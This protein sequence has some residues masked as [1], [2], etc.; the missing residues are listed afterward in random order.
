MTIARNAPS[1]CSQA[2]LREMI[3][4]YF[5]SR[6]IFVA[7][8]YDIA[9]R[10]IHGPKTADELATALSVHAPA[11]YRLLRALA[12][13]GIFREDEFGRFANT[14]M[15]EYLRDDV[16]DS[17]R[18]I[19]LLFGDETSWKCWED[20]LYCVET[21]KPSFDR[22]Y[23]EPFWDYLS[24]NPAKAA[25]FDQAMVSASMMANDAIV[26]AYDFSGVGTVVDVAGGIGSTLC[27]ILDA[28]PRIRG[29]LLDLP[30]LAERARKCI[31]ERGLSQRC[32]FRS[33]SFFD[34]VPE[35]AEIYFMKHIVHDWDDERCLRLLRNCRRAMGSQGKL[36][37]CE[38]VTPP[39]NEPSPGKWAD[40][41]MLVHTQGGRER[42]Q[43]EYAKLY[44]EAGF[45]LSRVIPTESAWS[46]IEGI[47]V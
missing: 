21:G 11:L 35:G 42:T 31:D 18:G 10:L 26:S 30:H 3:T 43:A 6:A 47:P 36:L 44:D 41:H 22:L 13:A 12:S 32:E 46:L 40:L 37:V 15:S 4:S 29:I 9:T 23:G 19:T 38:R 5:V 25:M 20:L 17:L 1:Q 45:L 27:A 24:R 34:S 2:K 33:G 14:E 28:Y 39:G 8:R 16:P 7:A